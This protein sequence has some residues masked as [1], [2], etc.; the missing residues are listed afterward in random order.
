MENTR[1]DEKQK[2]PGGKQPDEI[3]Y[4]WADRKRHLGLPL[5]FTQYRISDDRLF[6]E[7]GFLNLRE[8]EILLYRVRDIRLKMSLAQRMMGVGTVT[9]ISSD[10]SM[11][12]LEL[13]NIRNPRQVKELLHKS[14]EEAKE[15]RRIHSMEVMGDHPGGG[16]LADGNF[17]DDDL[18]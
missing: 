6:L 5:S 16:P 11:P 4:L 3:E 14:V 13:V 9:V 7:K 12:Q 2:K 17:D 10:Q 18:N 15:R 1:K 8:D